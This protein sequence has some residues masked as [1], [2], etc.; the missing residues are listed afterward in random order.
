ML[1]PFHAKRLP[2]DKNNEF[3][4]AMYHLI[5]RIN[6]ITEQGKNICAL[7]ISFRLSSERT[8]NKVVRVYALAHETYRDV[9]LD[10]VKKHG[11]GLVLENSGGDETFNFLCYENT[12]EKCNNCSYGKSDDNTRLTAW[13]DDIE[14]HSYKKHPVRT[15]TFDDWINH[16][17]NNQFGRFA[18]CLK[19]PV[20]HKGQTL[21]MFVIFKNSPNEQ[22]VH[23]IM[24]ELKS[25]ISEHGLEYA[26]SLADTLH[27]VAVKSTIESAVAAVMV[28]NLSHNIGSHVLANLSCK[29]DLQERYGENKW[30]TVFYD[31]AKCNAYLKL[32]MDF[33]ADIAT[34]VPAIQ[35]PKSLKLI[36]ENFRKENIL[37][38]YISG[39][40]AIRWHN[41]NIQNQEI[42]GNNTITD[43][44]FACTNESLGAH[45]FY[46]ILE[47]IIRNAVK[48]TALPKNILELTVRCSESDVGGHSD[49]DCWKVDII[50]NTKVLINN[51]DCYK[52]YNENLIDELNDLIKKPILEKGKVRYGGWGVLEMKIAAAYLRML[53]P[54]GIESDLVGKEL[55][56]P[57]LR[58]SNEEGNLC[59]T[60][61]L[62]KV[63]ELAILTYRE[64]FTIPNLSD[65]D[66]A[67][68]GIRIFDYK[69]EKIF[70]QISG[71]QFILLVAPSQDYLYHHIQKANSISKRIFISG[72]NRVESNIEMVPLDLKKLF[73]LVEYG[74]DKVEIEALLWQTWAGELWQ[75]QYPGCKAV[76][77]YGKSEGDIDDYC[78]PIE[79]LSGQICEEKKLLFDCHG[80]NRPSNNDTNMIYYEPF[81]SSS[82]SQKQ[83]EDFKIYTNVIKRKIYYELIDAALTKI[84]VIDERI[85]RHIIKNTTHEDTCEY[86]KMNIFVPGKNICDLNMQS[87]RTKEFKTNLFESWIN[88]HIQIGENKQEMTIFLVVHL[89]VIEKLVG[90]DVINIE[91]WISRYSKKGVSIVVTSGRGKPSNIPQNTLFLHYSVISQYLL[92]NRS[93]YYLTKILYASREIKA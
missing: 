60:F 29:S 74:I 65:K 52:D 53:P 24:D 35:V 21:V 15:P 86:E 25:F 28:R 83:L 54:E 91:K 39:S 71:Y 22:Q 20:K 59:Y 82:P 9:S 13:V 41:I 58:A 12:S 26:L 45:A 68:I 36:I 72:T 50:D 76:L 70:D 73:D 8:I 48:H 14:F 57:L 11:G 84:V 19:R 55:D 89:G 69:D 18:I 80:E 2:L 85:Q 23:K 17:K 62:P 46:V 27:T 66:F 4:I 44:I 67:N 38:D 49:N 90:T 10:F 37:L 47:N 77:K 34:S 79:Q 16:L 81:G 78:E 92:E 1:E 5:G 40:T 93:K 31:I 88:E 6:K 32:R 33:L 64:Y 42:V 51:D 43:I 30:E 61:Y 3:R 63:K 87:Y 7:D 56:T 75:K